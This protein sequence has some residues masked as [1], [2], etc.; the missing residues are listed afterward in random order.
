MKTIFG[1]KEISRKVNESLFKEVKYKHEPEKWKWTPSNPDKIR[2][3]K[4]IIEKEKE[5]VNYACVT[6]YKPA[7][8]KQK[9]ILV[10]TCGNLS[11]GLINHLENNKIK[12]FFLDYAQ[13]ILQGEIIISINNLNQTKYLKI[14]DL[15]LDLND[16]SAVIWNPP[17]YM[18]PLFDFN[19]IPPKRGRN[20]F[21]FKKRWIQFLR[22]LP[23]LLNE[24]VEWIPGKP[25]N[26]SQ[27]WQNKIGE[28][29]LA[30]TIG[31]HIP[32][33]IFTNSLNEFKRFSDEHGRNLV[34]RE[35]S[36]PPYSFP[37]IKIDV[38]NLNFKDFKNSP[39]CFQKYIDKLYELRIVVLF[40]K[41]YPCKIYSQDSELAKNDWRVYDD[42]NVKWELIEIS[43]ELKMKIISLNRK[44]DLNWSSIDLIYGV[45]NNYY[46]LEANRPGAHY[47]LEPFIGLDITREIISELMMRNY[48]EFVKV[49]SFD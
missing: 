6:N 21:M 10:F 32:P 38:D 43:N 5:L 49:K 41:V 23:L 47:W 7:S 14:E 9:V 18:K 15:V 3:L 22:E 44:L 29:N 8:E 27:D 28:Y 45:D 31:F 11:F 42:E 1:L 4:Q 19:H 39:V 40:D 48:V 33:T 17:K 12:Y 16:V 36:T 35:F 34:I 20:K 26:G 24:N 2:K 30:K 46:F 37:P 13:L 25:F